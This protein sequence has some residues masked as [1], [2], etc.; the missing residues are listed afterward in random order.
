MKPYLIY[1]DDYHE[2]AGGTM[3]LHFLCHLLNEQGCKAYLWRRRPV[4]H[5]GFRIFVRGQLRYWRDRFARK[6]LITNPRF[7]TPE[8]F[9]RPD[10][11]IAVYPEVIFGNPLRAPQVVRWL[12][13]KPGHRGGPA[14]FD[15]DDQ[16]FFFRGPF[17]TLGLPPERSLALSYVM[18][19]IYVEVPGQQRSGSCCLLRKGKDRAISAEAREA[20][21]VDGLDHEAMAQVFN[22]VEILISYDPYTMYNLYAGLCGCI[23][24]VIP[25]PGVSKEQWMANPTDRLGIAYGFDDIPHAIETRDALKAEIERLVE[26]SAR[27]VTKFV[28]MTQAQSNR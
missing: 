16:V 2:N 28:T 17:N 8:L 27:E 9:D 19:D 18:S 26:N 7:N 4:A 6:P 20:I 22:Q 15:K 1:C 23:P 12:L 11:F 24:V 5:L 14:S 13:H 3:M 21:L 25:E 10:D